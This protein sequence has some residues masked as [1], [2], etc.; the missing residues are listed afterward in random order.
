MAATA[1][2]QIKLEPD[3]KQTLQALA[4]YYGITLSSFV[5]MKLKQLGREEKKKMVISV[6]VTNDPEDDYLLKH[7]KRIVKALEKYLEDPRNIAEIVH[8]SE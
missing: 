4:Q 5:K 6:P 7:E 2:L 3:L 1:L 8:V